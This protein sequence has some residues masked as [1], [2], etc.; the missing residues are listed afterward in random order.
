MGS[1]CIPATQRQLQ[2]QKLSVCSVC[3]DVKCSL[4]NTQ[5]E[6][7]SFHSNIRLSQILAAMFFPFCKKDLNVF[8]WQQVG[9]TILT[10]EHHSGFSWAGSVFLQIIT[11]YCFYKE[12]QNSCSLS[13]SFFANMV[14]I[15][16]FFLLK[17]DTQSKSCCS[18]FSFEI[19][20]LLSFLLKQKL[21]RTWS[22]EK[23]WNKIK[24]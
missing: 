16:A 5:H 24:R 23:S 2:H 11:L 15:Y 21:L 22:L 6:R 12:R 9:S 14:K 10:V 8:A 1:G 20:M 17:W 19:W 4:A 18:I 7:M 13:D 3:H